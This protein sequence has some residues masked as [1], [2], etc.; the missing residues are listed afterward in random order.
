MDPLGLNF[1]DTELMKY[2]FYEEMR[3]LNG[4]VLMT[5]FNVDN[6]LFTP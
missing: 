2:I 4:G 6:S 1:T 3:N 5:G